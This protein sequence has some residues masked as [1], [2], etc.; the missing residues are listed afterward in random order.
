MTG[1]DDRNAENQHCCCCCCGGGGGGGG[2]N[3]G[4]VDAATVLRPSD[5]CEAQEESFFI[6]FVKGSSR[7]CNMFTS[8]SFFGFGAKTLNKTRV[9]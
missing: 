3:G 5:S 9:R 6:L 1:G 2:G 7:Y 4:V 8:S